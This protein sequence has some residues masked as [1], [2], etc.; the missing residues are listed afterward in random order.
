MIPKIFYNLPDELINEIFII[1]WKNKFKDV[2]NQ[3]KSIKAF[4]LNLKSKFPY[5]SYNKSFTNSY[6]KVSIYNKNINTIFSEKGS[7][8][9]CKNL[10]SILYRLNTQHKIFSDNNI[11]MICQYLC[12]KSGIMRYY[13]LNDY[14]LLLNFI[15]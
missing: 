11:G 10:D 13:I 9:F 12:S 6:K 1:H 7:K 15:E 2:V 4:C 5:N 8:L 14:R 3:M